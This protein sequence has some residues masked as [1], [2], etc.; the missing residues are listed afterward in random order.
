MPGSSVDKVDRLPLLGKATEGGIALRRDRPV[1]W[2]ST[3]KSRGATEGRE[4]E[5]ILRLRRKSNRAVN[6]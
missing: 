1:K 6:G 5:A 4:E 3:R 2:K